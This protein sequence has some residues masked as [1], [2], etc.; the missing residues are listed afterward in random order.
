[1]NRKAY[2]TLKDFINL[3]GEEYVNIYDDNGLNENL[4]SSEIIYEHLG[5]EVVKYKVDRA[6]PNVH[7]KLGVFV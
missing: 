5:R 1:M 7:L 6:I 4:L 3:I 2:L